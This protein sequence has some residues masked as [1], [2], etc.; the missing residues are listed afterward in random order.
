MSTLRV[1][2]PLNAYGAA[3]GGE[4]LAGRKIL[5]VGAG[6]QDYGLEDPPV[7]NGRAMSRL[8]AR[9]GAQVAVADFDAA[10]AGETARQVH[11]E[12]SA[13]VTIVADVGEPTEIERMVAEARDGMDG[14][15]GL[16]ANVGIVGG[17]GLDHTSA[18]D[19]DR[20]FQINVR[21]HYLTCKHALAVMP[22][23][24]AIV[25]T[26]SIAALMPA[27]EVVAYHSSKAA[28]DGLCMWLAKHAAPRKIRVNI[29][30]PGL[31]DTSL[32]RLA[33]KAD[34]SRAERPI[35][36]GRQGT[37]WD[38]AYAVVFLLS[39]EASYITGHSLPV[40]GGLVALR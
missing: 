32:G 28:L 12:G 8:F 14:L 3:L 33:S 5:V 30:V 29:V 34:P 10:A 2:A 7:G 4:R 35:P 9:E 26:S 21:A 27:N 13:A 38:V 20:V 31:I 39:D 24:A 18:E 22:D 37:A 16:V 15:D 23:G 1:S 6:Q 11:S 36:L 40:D 17:W 19:W 25:L